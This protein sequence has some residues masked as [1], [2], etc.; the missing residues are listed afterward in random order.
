MRM[1]ECPDTEAIAEAWIAERLANLTVAQG[2]PIEVEYTDLLDGLIFAQPSMAWEAL[3]NISRDERVDPVDDVFGMGPLSSFIFQCGVDFREEIHD[4]WKLNYRF[5]EQYKMVV[6]RDIAE[7][8]IA[9]DSI[10]GAA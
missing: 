2:E 10:V 1:T 7:A 6:F 9:P 5:R 3:K 8:I 4:F